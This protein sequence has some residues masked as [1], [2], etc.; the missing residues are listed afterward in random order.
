MFLIY[1]ILNELSNKGGNN[2]DDEYLF[3]FEIYEF[4]KECVLTNHCVIALY[5]TVNIDVAVR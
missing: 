5:G 1:G 2:F 3:I 4:T